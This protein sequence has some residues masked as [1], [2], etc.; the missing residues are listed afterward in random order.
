M[1]TVGGRR[2]NASVQC[3]TH[4]Q[5]HDRS[6]R[7]H[8][9]RRRVKSGQVRSGQASSAQVKAG[10]VTS[11][12]VVRTGHDKPRYHHRHLSQQNTRAVPQ[13]KRD[14]DGVVLEVSYML[15]YWTAP[16]DGCAAGHVGRWTRRGAGRSGSGPKV[17]PRP[18]LVV[19]PG[20]ARPGQLRSGQNRT[21][22]VRPCQIRA[23][24]VKSGQVRS[25]HGT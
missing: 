8:G 13:G 5:R 9:M 4:K 15:K 16:T 14:A 23:G 20:R 19:E 18:R 25:G 21:R 22:P 11:R 7:E 6:H 17:L 3:R 10:Q 1:R 2:L 24:Q 12:N